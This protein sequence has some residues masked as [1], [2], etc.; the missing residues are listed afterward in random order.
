M[1]ILCFSEGALA[2]RGGT[3]IPCVPLL[4]KA[5]ITKESIVEL[6]LGGCLPPGYS[7]IADNCNGRFRIH[8]FPA[9]GKWS[10]S[11]KLLFSLL[12]NKKKPDI[13][14]LHSLYSFAVFVGYIYS[15]I[16]K[17]PYII[18]PHGVLSAQMRKKNPKV[19]WIYNNFLGNA[20]LNNA[21]SIICTSQSELDDVVSLNLKS[22]TSLIPHG[23]SMDKEISSIK[24]GMFRKKFSINNESP[25]ILFIGRL[26]MIKGLDLLLDAFKIV[27]KNIPA[28]VLALVGPAD[29]P[30]Y[31]LTL[32]EA[33]SKRG[34]ND[35]VVVTGPL[36][37]DD[38]S[39][40][41]IDSN[42]FVLPSISE[43]FGFVILEAQAHELPVILS[44]TIS[45]GV[46]I[47][48]CGSG[49]S[50][51]RSPIEFANKMELLINNPE[52]CAEMGKNGAL[53]TK[54]FSWESCGQKLTQLINKIINM[55][56]ISLEGIG[57]E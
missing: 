14:V 18:W 13:V 24:K 53:I 32:L 19:K 57:K 29:P 47:E 34:I 9:F 43:N 45:L 41:F 27:H 42:F 2:N 54:Q 11:P 4:S 26:T 44:N 50:I 28:A 33:I 10:I 8:A 37:V 5:M 39:E 31:E 35:K 49:F 1:N 55:K 46:E 40:A 16:K 38:K 12:R 3:G 48:K 56:I 20:I 21:A 51:P 22:D 30:E 15:R 7:E 25:I 36:Y 52:L 23:F 17:V 6:F